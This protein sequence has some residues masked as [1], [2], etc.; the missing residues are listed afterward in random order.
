MRFKKIVQHARSLAAVG[1]A[2]QLAACGGGGDHAL[3]EGTLRVSLAN[4]G[5]NTCGYDMVRIAVDSVMVNQ[6]ANA[7]PGDAGWQPKDVPLALRQAKDM[8]LSAQNNNSPQEVVTMSVPAGNYAQVRLWLE[9]NSALVVAP[10][11]VMQ[12]GTKI[13]LD[14]SKAATVPVPYAFTVPANGQVDL[15]LKLDVCQSIVDTGSMFELKSAPVI[16]AMSTTGA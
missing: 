15:T 5:S 8:D 7:I 16:T 13:T 14:T 12:S 2:A 3:A 6:S 11:W 10:S 4:T 1:V 9:Q